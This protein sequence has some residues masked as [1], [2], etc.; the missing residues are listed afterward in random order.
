MMPIIHNFHK[1]SI[2]LSK[3]SFQLAA[4]PLGII[5]YKILGRISHNVPA[6]YD[7][8]AARIRALRSKA[9]G[10]KNVGEQAVGTQ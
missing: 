3:Y 7:V 8:F 10:C 4:K 9:Q 2:V 5:F 1:M 6:V